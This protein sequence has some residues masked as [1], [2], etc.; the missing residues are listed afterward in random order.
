MP[1]ESLSPRNA[2]KDLSP[3]KPSSPRPIMPCSETGPKAS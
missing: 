1:L 3:K 2:V